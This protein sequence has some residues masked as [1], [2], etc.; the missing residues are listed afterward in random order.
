MFFIHGLG[1]CKDAFDDAFKVDEMKGFSLMAIDLPGFGKSSRPRGFSYSLEDQAEV[2]RRVLDQIQGNKIHIVGH[3]MGGAIGLLLAEKMS[4]V[5]SFIDI[6]GNLI[7]ED[8]GL[9]SRKATVVSFQDFKGEVFDQLIA[10]IKQSREKGA[11][12][13]ATWNTM[14]DPFAFYRSA[15]S[16]VNWSDSRNLLKKLKGLA[17]KKAYIYGEKN[18]KMA[19]LHRLGSI[20]KIAISKSGHFVM[21][22]NPQEFYKVLGKALGEPTKQTRRT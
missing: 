17:I 7:S 19:V 15:Q 12:L 14:S 20:K 4:K 21:N 6:E 22:D 11:R 16:L 1:C 9:L 5:A 8:C 13:W 2:C 10:K 18:T 3:S